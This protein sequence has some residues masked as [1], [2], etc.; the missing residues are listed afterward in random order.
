MRVGG[1]ART[2]GI[3]VCAAALCWLIC[4]AF[5]DEVFS[6]YSGAQ[7]WL[8]AAGPI[9]KLQPA[10]PTPRDATP[11]RG[12]LASAKSAAPDEYFPPGVLACDEKRDAFLAGWYSGHLKALGEPALWA[13][14]RSD[15]RARVYRFLWLRTFDHPVSARVVI[16]HDLTSDLVLKVTNGAGGYEPGTLIRNERVPIGKHGTSLLLAQVTQTGFWEME[17]RRGPGGLD[18]AE[19]ILEAVTDGRYQIVNRW[20]PPKIDPVYGLGMTFVI[21]LAHMRLDPKEIY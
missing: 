7:R 8:A 13:L 3:L 9:Q 17:T 1:R 2:A 10:N 14:S 6:A 15:S 16:S 11:C 20:S 12:T 18:G 4:V 19:W 5:P 21:G